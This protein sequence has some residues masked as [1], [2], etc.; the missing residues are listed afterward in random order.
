MRNQDI[1][2][3]KHKTVMM[4]KEK[5]RNRFEA[6]DSNGLVKIQQRVDTKPS[7]LATKQALMTQMTREKG[8]KQRANSEGSENLDDLDDSSNSSMRERTSRHQFSSSDSSP[9]RRL[10]EQQTV[11]AAMKHFASKDLIPKKSEPIKSKH[12]LLKKR[13]SYEHSSADSDS[14]VDNTYTKK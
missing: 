9:E 12:G 11:A 13:K 6:M 10:R 4:E 14:H 5:V 7:N 3:Q 1:L 2:L 8:Y